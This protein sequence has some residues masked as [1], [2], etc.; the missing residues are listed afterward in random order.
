MGNIEQQRAISPFVAILAV[1][2]TFLLFLFAGSFIYVLAGTGPMLVFGELLLIVVPL[3]LMLSKKIDIRRYVGIEVTPK[4]LLLGIAFGVILLLVDVV[5]TGVLVS[6]FG[7]S[8]AIEESNQLIAEV[9]SSPKGL[10]FVVL[11]LFLTGICEEFTFR[12]FLQTSINGKYPFW[13]ALITSS[14]AFGLTHFDPQGIYIISAFVM[15]LMLGLIYHHWHSYV[16]S[17]TAHSTMNLIILALM[18]LVP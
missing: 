10:I 2:A 18:L 12:G 1:V 9:A 16:D 13:V 17:A 14:L 5:I 6:I 3:I 15:G 4:Y 8:N 7:T 11:S